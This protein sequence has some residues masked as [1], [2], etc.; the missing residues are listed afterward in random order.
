[1]TTIF[2]IITTLIF[3]TI[4]CGIVFRK[5]L[6]LKIIQIKYG[7]YSYEF[8]KQFKKFTN[9]SPFP[10]CFKDDI[11]PYLRLEQNIKVSVKNFKS[12]KPCVFESIPF[13]KFNYEVLAGKAYPECFNVFKIKNSELRSYGYYNNQFGSD[14]KAVFYFFD[15]IFF[16]GEYIFENSQNIDKSVFF[17]D[18]I[19][20][21][22][23]EQIQILNQFIVLCEN[24]TSIFYYD[25][26]FTIT[27]R[28]S[29]L[30]NTKFNEIIR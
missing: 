2:Y 19:S 22:D 9:K 25:N 18:L 20:Q 27:I 24:N 6:K 29:D 30:S 28:Y 11:L 13:G 12:G 17:K 26:G 8:V 10:Y 16:M 15:N 14:A 3:I 4:L 21:N 7:R 1:M 23:M 5:Q